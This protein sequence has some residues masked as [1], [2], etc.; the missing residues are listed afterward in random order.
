VTQIDEYKG[1]RTVQVLAP[2]GDF[3]IMRAKEVGFLFVFI[4]S[5]LL[6]KVF[7]CLVSL[8]LSG[9]NLSSVPLEFQT[10]IEV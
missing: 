2:S 8:S 3:K 6:M 1:A 5:D 10:V 9:I 7:P 4:L